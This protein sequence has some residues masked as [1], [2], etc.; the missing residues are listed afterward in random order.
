MFSDRK[1][2]VAGSMSM[3]TCGMNLRGVQRA[4]PKLVVLESSIFK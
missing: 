2:G 1:N 3:N 4:E